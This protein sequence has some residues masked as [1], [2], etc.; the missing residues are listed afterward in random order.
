MNLKDK[1]KIYPQ[2]VN[3]GFIQKKSK[4]DSE[5]SGYHTKKSNSFNGRLEHSLFDTIPKLSANPLDFGETFLK[6]K[7]AVNKT[8]KL[9][10]KIGCWKRL[11]VIMKLFITNILDYFLILSI[12]THIW[13]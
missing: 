7:E 12:I 3:T 4:K 10:S 11:K 2:S 6:A 8:N 1:N 13:K 9:L 5:E